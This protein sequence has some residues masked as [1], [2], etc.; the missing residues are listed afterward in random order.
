MIALPYAIYHENHDKCFLFTHISKLKSASISALPSST[1]F[2]ICKD[3][4]L[5][6]PKTSGYE[7]INSGINTPITRSVSEGKD[8]NCSRQR[9]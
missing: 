3:I 2:V 4:H 6:V 8:R 5:H 9:T 7:C 1:K